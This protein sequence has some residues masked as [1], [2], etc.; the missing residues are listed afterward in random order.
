M[1]VFKFLNRSTNVPRKGAVIETGIR[2]TEEQL[3]ILF[4]S[5]ISSV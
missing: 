4:D 5:C 1:Y 2:K 3:P